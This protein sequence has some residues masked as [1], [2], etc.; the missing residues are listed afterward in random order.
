MSGPASLKITGARELGDTAGDIMA[1]DS[2][3]TSRAYTHN[4]LLDRDQG[5][6]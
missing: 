1:K 4:T 5:P 6:R 3:G 2:E